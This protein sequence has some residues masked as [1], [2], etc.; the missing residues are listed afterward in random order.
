MKKMI[1]AVV[2]LA[3]TA[4][5]KEKKVTDNAMSLPIEVATPIERDVKLTREYPGYLDA[6]ATIS[7]VGRVNGT[8]VKRN[9]VEG[10]RVKKGDL[11][12]VIEPTLYENSVTQ[13]QAALQ[14]AKA[15]LDYARSNYERMKVAMSSNAVSEIEFLQ[16]K[17]RVESCEAAVDNARASLSSAKTKLAYC[18]VKA[19]EDGVVG[20]RNYSVGAYV[21]GEMNPVEL[22]K[23]YK[24]D[25]MYAYFN[26][27]D[28][29]WMQRN[30]NMEHE[31]NSI[32][33][34]MGNGKY[35]TW[36]AAIDYLAPNV[37]TSTGTMQLRAILKNNSGLLKPGSYINVR[38]PYDDIKNA[39][40]VRDA[41]IGTDQTGKFIYVV[42]KEDRVEYRKII[43]GSIVDDTMRV[44]TEGLA[45]DERYV[46]YALL[47]VRQGM[48]IT[49][50]ATK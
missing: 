37:N 27:T 6:D 34:T 35:F 20:L 23:L 47:K 13:A 1:F 15:E 4:C 3:I 42:D 16:A 50:V 33:F 19:P 28:R 46:T 8:I 25:I 22:C 24:D 10:G 40:L 43:T 30:N 38:L 41:S 29:Q 18:Y 2:L 26:I 36:E 44:V 11:L 9:F 48:P 49:P 39:V 7:I 14:T 5:H 31:Y 21:S 17:S 45:P 12:F 32:T